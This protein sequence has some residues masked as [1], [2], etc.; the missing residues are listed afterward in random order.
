MHWLVWYRYD[1]QTGYHSPAEQHSNTEAVCATPIFQE[2]EVKACRATPLVLWKKLSA[3]RLE[4]AK[5][6]TEGE[7]CK[8]GLLTSAAEQFWQHK[9]KEPHKQGLLRHTPWLRIH[10]LG[11]SK[12]R[13][14]PLPSL[15]ETTSAPAP[16]SSGRLK[17]G[18]QTRASKTQIP[19]DRQHAQEEPAHSN[20]LP[21]HSKTS[22]A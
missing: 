18:A 2:H 10:L 14:S 19:S 12:H 7:P 5:D 13:Q 17:Q 6:R 9:L 15:Q 4:R 11:L 8:S 1:G 22:Q 3:T 21:C 20:Y 16:C